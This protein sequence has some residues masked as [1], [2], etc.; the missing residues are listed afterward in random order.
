[1]NMEHQLVIGKTRCDAVD[2]Q[3]YDKPGKNFATPIHAWLSSGAPAAPKAEEPPAAS[4]DEKLEEVKAMITAA[5][6][7]SGVEACAAEIGRL[8]PKGDAPTDIRKQ[9]AS[10]YSEALKFYTAAT[11]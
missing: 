1:M 7:K 3:F 2:G 11:A 5:T 4:W 10:F 6:D 9:A 8:L